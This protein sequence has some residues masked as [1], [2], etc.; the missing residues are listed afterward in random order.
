MP[1]VK[2]NKKTWGCEYDWSNQGEEWSSLWGNSVMQWYG[3]ILPR[4]QSHVPAN[5]I[6]EIAC[7]FGRWTHFLKDLCKNLSVIDISEK[8]ISACQKRFSNCS[9]IEYHVNDG[10]SL[11]LIAK[12][13]IDFVFSFDS[14]VHVDETVI[15]AY[16]SQFPDIL[17]KKGVA[18][19]HHSN[20]GEYR[21][22]YDKI[23]K[24]PKLEGGLILLGLL[25]KFLHWRD[26]NVDA[27]LV[28]KISEKYGL[29]CISQE[30][31][32]WKTEKTFM[33]CMST[34]VVR[35]SS[36]DRTNKV[37]RNKYFMQEAQN[38]LQLSKLYHFNQ[39]VP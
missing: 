30:L 5:N 22:K 15:D 2:F 9:H 35:G 1:T 19:I 37:F 8:S 32:M 11:D 24:I 7:G 27:K 3:S 18:F 31:I 16:L 4:I 10:K 26:F 25:D 21:W 28:E 29:K 20:L 39:R 12:N 6:L 34:I 23:R 36:L 33:D 17:K 13:S 38:L 14:L